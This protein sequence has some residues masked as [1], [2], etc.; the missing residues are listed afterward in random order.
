MNLRTFPV[1]KASN[2]LLVKTCVPLVVT[3]STPPCWR[4]PVET[5]ITPELKVIAVSVPE[6][7]KLQILLALPP[8][9]PCDG[10]YFSGI[11]GD[12]GVAGGAV[13]IG[14]IDRRA[15]RY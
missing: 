7:L 8:R 15:L 6:R 5:L 13:S 2:V 11:K 9:E 12:S 10:L 14:D 3:T 4:V 1:A